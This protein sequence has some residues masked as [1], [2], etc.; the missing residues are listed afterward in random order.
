MVVYSIIIPAYNE[1]ANIPRC[2]DAVTAAI[3]DR[4]DVEIIVVDDGSTDETVALAEQRGARI[5][6]PE[7]WISIAA[8]RNLGGR[9]AKGR[10]LLFLDAD[11]EPPPTWFETIESWFSEGRAD[12]L[13]FVDRAPADAPWFA[14]VWSLRLEA[15]RET[16]REVDHL[17]GRNVCVSR[18]MF[19]RVGGFDEALITAED[20]DF[21]MR[22][23]ATGARVMSIAGFDFYHWGY[24]RTLWEL[25]RK[26]F[27]RQ[28]NHINLIRRHG[29]SLRVLRFPLV[30]AVHPLWA[31][32]LLI[33]L[34]FG[35]WPV[36]TVMF[37]L[38]FV[39]GFALALMYRL[40]RSSALL[41]IQF[42]ALYWLRLN[43]AG[44]AVLTEL[45]FGLHPR[46]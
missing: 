8:V 16:T 12:V 36:A 37:V 44:V 46:R 28:S 40:S 11:T 22:L 6:R 4:E 13:G 41:L 43:V 21:V 17:P 2:L 38:W 9:Q 24:E 29:L 3:K 42:T 5:V 35:S 33:V 10:I 30:S 19:D 14:L 15:E 18:E 25:V 32:A 26:E 7:H 31:A 34:L 45:L 1:A 27:W 20:K 23:K 39:T